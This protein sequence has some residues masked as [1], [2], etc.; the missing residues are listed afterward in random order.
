MNYH[1]QKAC[2][3][4]CLNCMAF[5]NHCASACLKEENPSEMVQCIQLD[6]EC[7]A[8]CVAA[9][10][11]MSL[12]SERAREWCNL[13]AD[14]CEQ[15]AEACEKHEQEHCIACARACRACAA[16]CRNM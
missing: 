4:A 13:C 2:I 11:L 8:A 15:C 5:C 9:A 1:D 7:A 12:G 14:L 10:Q 6:M 16:A 3:E